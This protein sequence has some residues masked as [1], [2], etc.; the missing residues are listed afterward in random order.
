MMRCID[1]MAKAHRDIGRGYAAQR[2]K[3]YEVHRSI[4]YNWSIEISPKSE[5]DLKN[6]QNLVVF[7]R[8]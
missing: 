2:A 1:N 6:E 8:C 5:D 7:N 4:E 3:V